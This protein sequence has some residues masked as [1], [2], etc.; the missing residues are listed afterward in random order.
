MNFSNSLFVESKIRNIPKRNSSTGR[1]RAAQ[2]FGERDGFVVQLGLLDEEVHQITHVLGVD[3]FLPV[4]FVGQASEK[5]SA[6]VGFLRGDVQFRRE[7]T[8]FRAV[9]RFLRPRVNEQR[10]QADEENGQR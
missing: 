2:T 1:G 5:F 4:V 9:D 8:F 3:Q 10:A 7:T 6:G